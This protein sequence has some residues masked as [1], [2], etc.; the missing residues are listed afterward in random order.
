[1]PTIIATNTPDHERAIT[2]RIKSGTTSI[3][4]EKPLA[5]NLEQTS[6]IITL[7]KL[8]QV[9][10]YTALLIRFSP[11]VNALH[12]FMMENNLIMTSGAV[13]WGKNRI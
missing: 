1:M 8:N 3:L 6:N 7:A 12:D 10:L 11:A 5:L 13:D 4:T 2:E 9:D